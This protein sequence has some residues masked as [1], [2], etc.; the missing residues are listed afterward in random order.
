MALTR[1]DSVASTESFTEEELNDVPECSQVPMDLFYDDDV[2]G[3]KV[4]V[5]R[6][7]EDLPI[8]ESKLKFIKGCNYGFQ[9]R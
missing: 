7:G 9:F 8:K 6:E 3:K 5:A 1:A 4:L 2:S